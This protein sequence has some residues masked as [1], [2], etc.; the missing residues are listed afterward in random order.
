MVLLQST[1][2]LSPI[3]V[4]RNTQLPSCVRDHDDESEAEKGNDAAITITSIRPREITTDVGRPGRQNK[5]NHAH[6]DSNAFP[7]SHQAAEMRV[8]S[9]QQGIG[10]PHYAH[11]HAPAGAAGWRRRRTAPA[12]AP[13]TAR[14]S[15]PPWST[16]AS[17]PSP[18]PREKEEDKQHN[19]YTHFL[20][21]N[22]LFSC[23][24][25]P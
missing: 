21:R 17:P 24:F 12:W 10:V 20:T 8:L 5:S 19:P 9:P 2:D 18:L 23:Q 16:A 15:W 11:P 22:S 3:S 13:A 6:P 14:G 25:S 4:L 7:V 1:E